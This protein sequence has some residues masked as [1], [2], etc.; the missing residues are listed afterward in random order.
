M[1]I[2]SGKQLYICICINAYTSHLHIIIGVSALLP[3]HRDSELFPW[4]KN[5][6]CME[7]LISHPG[8]SAARHFP[9]RRPGRDYRNLTYCTKIKR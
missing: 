4:L 2:L 8:L 1:E 7:D 9:A 5:D 3:E 6:E